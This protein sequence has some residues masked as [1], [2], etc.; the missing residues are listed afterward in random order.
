[1]SARTTATGIDPGLMARFRSAGGQLAWRPAPAAA[2][3]QRAKAPKA[4]GAR[5][6]H[7]HDE[8]SRVE[9]RTDGRTRVLTVESGPVGALV[10]V[11]AIDERGLPNQLITHE[12]GSVPGFSAGSIEARWDPSSGDRSLALAVSDVVS[13]ARFALV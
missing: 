9:E 4:V 12:A 7:L 10:L 11:L 8:E 5:I 13:L 1:V 3:T 6:A 2:R